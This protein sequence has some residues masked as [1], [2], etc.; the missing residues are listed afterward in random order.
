[1]AQR[2][3]RKK[4]GTHYRKKVKITPASLIGVV[5]GLTLICTGIYAVLEKGEYGGYYV[6][7]LGAAF[8]AAVCWGVFSKR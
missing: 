3:R 1:M 6:V 8:A 5:L 2:N 4:P 7:A